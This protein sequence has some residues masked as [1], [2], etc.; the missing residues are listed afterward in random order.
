MVLPIG[1]LTVF[2]A[3]WRCLAAGVSKKTL[4]V[5]W[6]LCTSCTN[7]L[8]VWIQPLI[9]QGN[10]RYV[11]IQEKLTF[12]C[13]IVVDTIVDVEASSLYVRLFLCLS[14]ECRRAA[15]YV[16][17]AS[18]CANLTALQR[19]QTNHGSLHSRCVRQID[20]TRHEREGRS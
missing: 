15:V 9:S 17:S 11:L 3:I 1:F 19:V 7:A 6:S 8:H 4:S 5:G 18:S 16:K 12:G 14:R 10:L 20:C 2:G 13:H